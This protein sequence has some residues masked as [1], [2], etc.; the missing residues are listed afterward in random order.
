MRLIFTDPTHFTMI[1]ALSSLPHV[2]LIILKDFEYTQQSLPKDMARRAHS[3]E[4]IENPVRD[5][6]GFSQVS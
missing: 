6:S 1:I 3:S 4:S 2:A 5:F